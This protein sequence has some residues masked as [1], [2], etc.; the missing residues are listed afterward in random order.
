MSSGFLNSGQGPVLASFSFIIVVYIA[1]VT[2][3]LHS[4]SE[5]LRSESSIEIQLALE[6]LE[7]RLSILT[8][9]PLTSPCTAVSAGQRRRTTWQRRAVKCRCG[10]QLLPCY[11]GPTSNV[12]RTPSIYRPFLILRICCGK[13]DL[14]FT[15]EFQP[16]KR[17][18][19]KAASSAGM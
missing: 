17:C 1:P 13:A 15:L 3:E 5:R 9:V 8:A 7:E 10:L 18:I 6:A 4:V 14:D 12:R 2:H 16:V 19:H 11:L